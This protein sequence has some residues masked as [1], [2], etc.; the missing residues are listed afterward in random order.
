L[1]A[2]TERCCHGQAPVISSWSEKLR[3][4]RINTMPEHCNALT[5]WRDG[6]RSDDV[7]GDQELEA[8]KYRAAQPPSKEFVGAATVLATNPC[9]RHEDGEYRTACDYGDT[10]RIDR[11]AG[12]LD[13]LDERHGVIVSPTPQLW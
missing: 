1:S 2:V 4:V 11:R 6:D 7:C 8:E 10:D 5:A 12:G 3:N 13:D 9:N